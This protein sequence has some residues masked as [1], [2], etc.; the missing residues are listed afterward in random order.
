MTTET[1]KSARKFWRTLEA[2]HTVVYFSPE[3]KIA[4]K[5]IGLRGY[6]S[7]Y[8]A[9]RSAP[10]GKPSAE[11]VT[12]T[13]FGFAPEMVAKAIPDAWDRSDVEE[14]LATRRLIA[15]RALDA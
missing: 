12:A 6:W 7:G 9:S 14:I 1:Q 10:M 11:L 4:Y 5:A 8:F 3:A 15:T 2:L 13:F